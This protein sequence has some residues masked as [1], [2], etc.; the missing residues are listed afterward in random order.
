MSLF[1]RVPLFPKIRYLDIWIWQLN[2]IPSY[3][4]QQDS[5]CKKVHIDDISGFPH[6][7]TGVVGI[8]SSESMFSGRKKWLLWFCEICEPVP[9]KDLPVQEVSERPVG[10]TECDDPAPVTN[11]K[12]ARMGGGGHIRNSHQNSKSA[13]NFTWKSVALRKK[14]LRC[15]IFILFCLWPNPVALF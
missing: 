1:P 10:R 8:T 7:W 12:S 13:H 5:I 14:C 9:R 4:F 15:V 2:F 6:C 3:L 11:G